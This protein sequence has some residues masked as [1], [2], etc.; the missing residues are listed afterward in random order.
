MRFNSILGPNICNKW[1]TF[2]GVHC[3]DQLRINSHR[4][5]IRKDLESIAL[6]AAFLKKKRLAVE[7]I[8][9]ISYTNA[10]CGQERS[11]HPNTIMSPYI[12]ILDSRSPEDGLSFLLNF[13]DKS[14]LFNPVEGIQRIMLEA[15]A[16]ITKIGAIFLTQTNWTSFGGLCG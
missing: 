6:V 3:I 16:K 14:Y 5:A 4:P 7:K 10:V 12:Q 1:R 9:A 13:N 8:N 15:G 2:R 11:I